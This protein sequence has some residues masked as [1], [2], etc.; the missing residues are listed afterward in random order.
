MSHPVYEIVSYARTKVG[1]RAWNRSGNTTEWR[2]VRLGPVRTS[3]GF[4]VDTDEGIVEFRC[5]PG[6]AK[7][8]VRDLARPFIDTRPPGRVK[9]LPRGL[10]KRANRRPEDVAALCLAVLKAWAKDPRQPLTR[11][12]ADAKLDHTSMRN[13]LVRS[14]EVREA[15]TRAVKAREELAAKSPAV[16]LDVAITEAIRLNREGAGFTAACFA[17]AK[18]YGVGVTGIRNG[19]TRLGVAPVM[20]RAGCASRARREGVRV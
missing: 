10:N 9:A 2:S 4:A 8:A 13:Y 16:P 11:A 3:E 7:D 6:L 15:H 12:C 20:E 19:F 14:P 1:V 17:A 5:S 18:K